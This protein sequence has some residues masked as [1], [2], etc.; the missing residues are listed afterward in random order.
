MAR[1]LVAGLG[2]RRLL[3]AL[4]VNRL[5]LFEQGT[6]LVAAMAVISVVVAASVRGV[7]LLLTDMALITEELAGRAARTWCRW[8][9]SSRCTRCW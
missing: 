5:P 9:P 7:V 4:P 2:G 8:W 6:A 3:A 1:W